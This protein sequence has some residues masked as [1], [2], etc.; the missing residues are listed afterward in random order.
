MYRC[1]QLFGWRFTKNNS[2]IRAHCYKIKKYCKMYNLKLL[3]GVA[4]CFALS[5]FGWALAEDEPRVLA[6]N[7]EGG[8]AE[9]VQSISQYTFDT[10]FSQLSSELRAQRDL[11]NLQ[12]ETLENKIEIATSYTERLLFAFMVAGGIVVFVVL[13]TLNKQSG[14]NN[15]RMRN[16]IRECESALE[17][18]H[19]LID[20]P[21]AEHFHVSRK[22]NRIMNK[23]RERDRP[24]LPQKEISDMYVAS[25]DPTLP[26]SLHLQANA[27]RCEQSGKWNDAIEL[28]ERLLA[29]ED[30]NPEV[31]LHLAQDYKHLAEVNVGEAAARMREVSLGYFQRYATRTNNHIHSERELRKMTS[32]GL[33]ARTVLQHSLSA[34]ERQTQSETLASQPESDSPKALSFQEYQKLKD[35]KTNKMRQRKKS[36]TE[37]LLAIKPRPIVVKEKASKAVN[38]LAEIMAIK[39]G[40]DSTANGEEVASQESVTP[41]V[42]I[43]TT[44]SASVST[45]APKPQKSVTAAAVAETSS[46]I[47]SDK[48]V[49]QSAAKPVEQISKPTKPVSKVSEKQT[50][51]KAVQNKPVV[52]KVLSNKQTK[53]AELAAGSVSGNGSSA[54]LKRKGSKATTTVKKTLPAPIPKINGIVVDKKGKSVPEQMQLTDAEREQSFKSRMDKAKDYFKRYSDATKP[55]D[56]LQWLQTAAEE[57]KMAATYK[58]DSNLYRIWGTTMLEM[59]NMDPGNSRD[60][61]M[62]AVT[63]FTNGNKAFAGMYCNDLALCHAMLEDEIACRSN[64]EQAHREGSLEPDIF[65]DLPDFAKYKDKPWYQELV[66]EFNRV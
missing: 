60:H 50:V 31:M 14:V 18:L 48:A 23:M 37:S 51:T 54:K 55:K 28:W 47:Q 65:I 29:I 44:A 7:D 38:A 40:G 13:V 39:S 11:A 32:L 49:T 62:R 10:Q 63:V 42:T 53:H 52:A 19:R 8:T 64:L 21:E 34:T 6:G 5:I 26:V 41:A 61:V 46:Q 24:S 56:K 43:P 33:N 66:T 16:L 3:L 12:L 15:E 45:Q 36:V 57:Y 17:D 27:L 1:R 35:T 58:D 2:I 20:R 59:A 4:L 25:E 22:L 9:Q 30:T